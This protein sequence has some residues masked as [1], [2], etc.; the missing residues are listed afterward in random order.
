M[1][2]D[3]GY[4]A[5]KFAQALRQGDQAEQRGSANGQG[6]QRIDPAPADADAR[7]DP[8]LRRH[9]VVGAQP[10]CR[11]AQFAAKRLGRGRLGRLGHS[12]AF[13]RRRAAAMAQ[14]RSLVRA[15]PLWNAIW[16]VLALWISYCGATR[17]A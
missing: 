11:I 5:G 17:L 15:A 7:R 1:L 6:P 14:S 2:L 3:E 9:P 16:S 13:C 8:L 10:V 12:I 4:D